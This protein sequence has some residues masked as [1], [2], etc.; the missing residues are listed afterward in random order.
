MNLKQRQ[1]LR[2][3]AERAA[4]TRPGPWELQTSNSFRRIWTRRG[5]GDVLCATTQRSDGHPDLLAHPDVLEFFV[6]TPPSVIIDLLDEIQYLEK[7][8]G[9]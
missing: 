9:H 8:C 7:L 5:D 2:D 1:K 6:A 4:T 3:V